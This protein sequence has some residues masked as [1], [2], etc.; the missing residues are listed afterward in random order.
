MGNLELSTA[1][2]FLNRGK[3]VAYPTEA[4]WGFGCDP[5]IEEAVH[6]ILEIKQRPVGK[7]LIL[8]AAGLTQI[9]ELTK[10]LSV[11]QLVLLESTWPGPTTWLIPDPKQ[12]FPRWVKGDHESIA[13]R[14]SGHP[15]VNALCSE[16]GKPIV[17]T[18]ANNTGEVEIRSRLILEEQ[19][20]DK[21]DY[22][23]DGELGDQDSPSKIRD[24]VT[25]NILR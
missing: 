16:F 5:Y 2:D 4:V 15:L 20:A 21:I 1:C 3:L 8:V 14:V 7:G 19:F 9:A 6:R 24:L 25:G 17:S 13:I 22:I 23:M 12:I 18:S 11:D 10:D